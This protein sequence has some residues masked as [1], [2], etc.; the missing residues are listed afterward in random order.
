MD[1]DRRTLDSHSRYARLDQ[2]RDAANALSLVPVES[3]N[4][5]KPYIPLPDRVLRPNEGRSAKVKME[6]MLLRVRKREA[7]A[8]KRFR[9]RGK[10]KPQNVPNG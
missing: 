8:S 6:E 2:R 3:T 7:D 9:L 10:Q 5:F 1:V 4:N